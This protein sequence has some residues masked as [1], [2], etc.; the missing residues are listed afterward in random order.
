MQSGFL[1]IVSLQM[2]DTAR[3][4]SCS[5]ASS[6][7]SSPRF[8]R[9]S[10]RSM[11]ASIVPSS[12]SRSLGASGSPIA[13]TQVPPSGLPASSIRI[14]TVTCPRIAMRSRSRTIPSIAPISWLPSR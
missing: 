7:A 14:D 8:I 9:A 12:P 1:P 10:A 5:I 3:V 4:A 11:S 2:R 6:C 13:S